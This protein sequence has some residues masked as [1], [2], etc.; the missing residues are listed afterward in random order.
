MLLLK[1]LPIKRKIASIVMLSSVLSMVIAAL[2]VLLYESFTFQPRTLRDLET[3]ASLYA[4]TLPA[5]LQFNDPKTASENL[6]ALKWRSEIVGACVYTTNGAIFAQYSRLPGTPFACPSSTPKSR[7]HQFE[8][9]QVSFF[10]PIVANGEV[11]GTIY[12]LQALPSLHERLPQYS[13]MFSAIIMSLIIISMLLLFSFNRSISK[14]ILNLARLSR[15]ISQSGNYSERAEKVGQDEIGELTDAYNWLLKIT[16]QSLLEQKNAQEELR[17]TQSLLIDAQDIAHIGTWEWIT[18]EET[19]KWTPELYRIYGVTPEEHTPTF[20]SYLQKVH[21]DDR[22]RVREAMSANFTSGAPFSHDEKILRPDGSVRYLHTWGHPVFDSDGTVVRMIGVCQDVTDQKIAEV[23]KQRYLSLLEATLESTAD[24]ILVVNQ[25]G[26]IA[27]YNQRYVQLWQIPEEVISTKDDEKALAF[28]QSKLQSSVGF[29]EKVSALYA[30]PDAESIDALELKSGKVLERFSRPQRILGKTIGRVWSFRDITERVH[31]EKVMKFLADSSLAMAETLEFNVTLSNV[32]HLAVPFI[33]EGCALD[34]V[35]PETGRL[36]RVAVAHVNPSLESLMQELIECQ[37]SMTASTLPAQIAVTT[38]CPLAISDISAFLAEKN[39]TDSRLAALMSKLKTRSVLSV[40]LFFHGRAQGALTFHSLARDR[41]GPNEIALVQEL[42]RRCSMAIE[43]AR[44]YLEAQKS[45]QIRDDFISIA[46]HELRTPLTPVKMQVQ[47]LKRYAQESM[48]NSSRLRDLPKLI[49]NADDQIDK[50][51]KLVEDMLDVSRISAG[52]LLITPEECDLSTLVRDI[53]KQYEESLKKSLCPLT[54]LADTSV[55][56]NW[57]RRRLEQVIVNLLSN[58]MKYGRG[59]PIE[60]SVATK[61]KTAVLA[62]RDHG[63]GIDK[64]AQSILFE[65]FV[66]VAPIKHYGGLGL[67]LYIVRNIVRAH[68][69]SIH[70]ESE[71]G[72]GAVF[73]VELPV[74]IVPDRG[75]VQVA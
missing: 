20:E 53:T 66:R 16:Q 27:T 55:K 46:S 59:K 18:S 52:R 45:I 7:K 22:E 43:N 17:R 51:Q 73:V 56:G 67:G 19:V 24:G 6:A 21:P 40:P 62:V 28:M 37:T 50:L 69:G 31:S 1:D 71:P 33:A 32:V 11:V 25:Q 30:N 4:E 63:I 26:K 47:L 74:G 75:T 35:N 60:I 13:I 64:E 5:A 58:A 2:A 12:F 15:R 29:L 49:A 23:E 57:D 36:E 44:L 48:N 10:E 9:D 41:Y 42:A 38:M 8:T 14:P 54:L 65:R 39:M 61:D 70:V 34:T 3:M 68:G 72:Q